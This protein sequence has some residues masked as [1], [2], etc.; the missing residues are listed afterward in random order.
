MVRLRVGAGTYEQYSVGIHEGSVFIVTAT[1]VGRRQAALS[2]VELRIGIV[3]P[4]SYIL[5]FPPISYNT[6]LQALLKDGEEA[7]LLMPQHQFE[8]E[9]RRIADETTRKR[10]D[11]K[12]VRIDV[13][14]KNGGSF[15]GKLN[16]R[17]RERILASFEKKPAVSGMKSA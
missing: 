13:H 15:K 5:F 10:L 12:F 1:N 3:L 11:R 16:P 4:Q 17:A 14:T 8:E 6:Q 2:T 9:I 7:M